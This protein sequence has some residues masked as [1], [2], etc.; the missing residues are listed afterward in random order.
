MAQAVLQ[1]TTTVSDHVWRAEEL[2]GLPAGYRYE[3]VEGVVYM[4]PMPAWPHGAVAQNLADLLSPWVRARKLGRILS[5]QTGIYYGAHNYLDPD[6]LYLR[7][8]QVPTHRGERVTQATL[9][10]EV[11][12]PSNLRASREDREALF[13]RAGLEELW[14]VDYDAR[15]LEVRRRTE[16]GF[17]TVRTF[18]G[19][20]QV[21]SESFP[22][23]ELPLAEVW[24]DLEA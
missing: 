12:S 22:G 5:A 17:T 11:L 2:D 23:L 9:A 1:R 13:H 6:L 15:T 3:L 19:D 4:A 14:Y 24:A 10:V 18:R 7:P 16:A 8:E 21:T 20:E